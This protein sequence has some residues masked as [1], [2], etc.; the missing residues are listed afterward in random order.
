MFTKKILCLGNNSYDTDQKV[1]VLA[2]QNQTINH[3]LISSVNFMPTMFGYYHT[4]VID[5][6]PGEII[7]LSKHFNVVMLLDQS[8]EEW[9]HPTLF[10]TTMKLIWEL[11]ELG[12]EIIFQNPKITESNMFFNELLET[13][14]SFCIYPF[15]LLTSAGNEVTSACVRSGGTP[16]TKIKNLTDWQ[17]DPGYQKIRTKMLAGEKIPEH[18]SYCYNLEKDGGKGV[19]YFD[20]IDW[21]TRLGLTSLDDLKKIT[22]PVHYEIRPSNKCNLK[23]RSCIPR[24]SHLIDQEFKNIGITLKSSQDLDS[25]TGF[26]LVKFDNLKRLFF[27]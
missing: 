18:C 16:I 10:S 24:H 1:S 13:N 22:T 6:H 23:C 8:S 26:D 19:R 14:K 3:V 17:N 5:L 20:T 12:R 4:T 27:K 7:R 2:T 9:S 25:Y 11:K 21:A 15:T